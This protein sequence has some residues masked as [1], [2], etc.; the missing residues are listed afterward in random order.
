MWKSEIQVCKVNIRPS[1]TPLP[2]PINDTNMSQAEY[3]LPMKIDE[4]IWQNPIIKPYFAKAMAYVDPI[5]MF[6]V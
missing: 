3:I 4:R 6:S 1:S 5:K 2:A